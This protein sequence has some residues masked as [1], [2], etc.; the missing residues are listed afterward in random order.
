MKLYLKPGGCGMDPPET[1][2]KL[3]MKP[4]MRCGCRRSMGMG[5]PLESTGAECGDGAGEAC[6][7]GGGAAEGDDV[8][9]DAGALGC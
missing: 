2:R 8:V 4:R 3:G 7:D 1:L 6:G 5:C 9:P